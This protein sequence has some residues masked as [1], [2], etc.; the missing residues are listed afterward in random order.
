MQV[1]ET[2]HKPIT[3]RLERGFEHTFHSL[4]DSLD[5][6]ENDWP[7]KYGLHHKRA[8]DLCRAAACRMVG[9]E[10]A[11]EAFLAACLKA[12]MP[13]VLRVCPSRAPVGTQPHY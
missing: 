10:V 3:V 7:I 2:W 4:E 8:L 6:L 9:L 1:V 13:M 5:C 12:N 11:R